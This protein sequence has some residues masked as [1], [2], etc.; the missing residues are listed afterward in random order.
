MRL[1]SLFEFAGGGKHVRDVVTLQR[2]IN[3]GGLSPFG[4]IRHQSL[5]PSASYIRLQWH[6]KS[7]HRSARARRLQSGHQGADCEMADAG[8][9]TG[10]PLA[11][12]RDIEW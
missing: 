5:P 9:V 3:G 7:H 11:M 4:E 2:R 6:Q 10:E 1:S 12:V 8:M